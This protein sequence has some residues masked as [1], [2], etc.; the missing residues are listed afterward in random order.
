M[1]S[2]YN[3]LK[4]RGSEVEDDVCKCVGIDSVKTRLKELEELVGSSDYDYE[5]IKRKMRDIETRLLQNL[6]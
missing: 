6:E 5:L 2:D 4:Y 1:D 3:S